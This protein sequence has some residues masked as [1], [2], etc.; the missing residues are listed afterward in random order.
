MLSLYFGYNKNNKNNKTI[1][2]YFSAFNKT[3]ITEEYSDAENQSYGFREFEYKAEGGAIWR[4]DGRGPATSVSSHKAFIIDWKS[5]S[6]N[7]MIDTGR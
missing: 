3:N 5:S 6:D 1:L 4:N 2:K 7:P